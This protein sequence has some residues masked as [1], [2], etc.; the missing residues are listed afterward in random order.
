MPDVVNLRAKR[1]AAG[2]A[3]SRAEADENA[4]KFGRTKGQKTREADDLV[5]AKA[6]L[7]GRKFEKDGPT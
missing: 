3:T 6:A 5:R 1:K 2:R 7:D 4:V